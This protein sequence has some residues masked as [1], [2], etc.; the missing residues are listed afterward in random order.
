MKGIIKKRWGLAASLVLFVFAVM[1][2]AMLLV[3]LLVVILHFADLFP[4]WE[5]TKHERMDGFS[6]LRAIFLML[7]FSAILGTAIAGFFSKKVL[8]PIRRLMEAIHQV[9]EG[10]FNTKVKLKGVYE[11]EELSQSFNKMT[12][13]LSSIETLRGDFVN[14]FSHEFKTPIVS[15]RGFAKLLKDGVLSEE[16]RLEYIDII[17]A[18]SERLAALSTNVLNLSKYESLEIVTKKIPFSV[19]EQIRRALVLMEPKWSAKELDIDVVMEE[20][21]YNGSVDLTQQVWLNLIDN[22]VKFSNNGG[23]LSIRLEC[24]NDGFRFAIK[25]NGTGMDDLTKA[26]IFDKFYQGDTSHA[27]AG[28]GLGLAIVKRIIELC[29]GTVDFQSEL[30]KGSEFIVWMPVG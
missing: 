3:G 6:T 14:N 28:N 21:T 24:W 13:E 19:D 17:I 25:D 23:K 12:Y 5:Y 7:M 15:I 26:H 20:V 30:L 27:K 9:A 22:A 11:L 1:M 8:R 10:N 4:V 29:G 18:E 16:E 2:S